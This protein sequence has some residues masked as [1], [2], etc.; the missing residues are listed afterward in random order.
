MYFC[1]VFLVL[2]T[3][4]L[5]AAHW[6]HSNEDDPSYLHLSFVENVHM[7]I[8]CHDFLLRSK[9]LLS[10]FRYIL[11]SVN[12]SSSHN[13]YMYDHL[14]FDYYFHCQMYQYCPMKS[15]LSRHVRPGTG[16]VARRRLQS[17]Q[18][19]SLPSFCNKMVQLLQRH[20]FRLDLSLARLSYGLLPCPCDLSHLLVHSCVL[21]LGTFAIFRQSETL[22]SDQRTAELNLPWQVAAWTMVYGYMSFSFKIYV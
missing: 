1:H 4:Y 16:V 17:R 3:K 2:S 11:L 19:H 14:F 12:L 6:S 10:L 20:S 22:H 15:G 5:L 9:T 18:W 13:M 21:Y 7:S 8:T